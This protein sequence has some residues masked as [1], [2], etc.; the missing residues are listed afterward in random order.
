MRARG[1]SVVLGVLALAAL[2][3]TPGYFAFFPIRNG[4]LFVAAFFS[5]EGETEG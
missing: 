2:V 1:K 3:V 5:A 4:D